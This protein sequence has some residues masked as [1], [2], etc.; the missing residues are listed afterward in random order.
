MAKKINRVLLDCSE[1]YI[2]NLNTGIQRVVKNIVKRSEKMS[3]KYGVT[4][5]PIVLDSKNGYVDLRFFMS[6]KDGGNYNNK[7]NNKLSAGEVRE[8]IKRLLKEN[9]KSKETD[10]VFKF[11]KF[12]WRLM[13]RLKYRLI[14]MR[15]SC[16]ALSSRLSA[17]LSPPPLS[18]Q[19]N[20]LLSSPPSAKTVL[21]QKG[22]LLILLDG[23]WGY[24]YNN[25]FASFCR[26]VKKK[27]G[28]IIAV[29]YDII[30]LTNPEFFEKETVMRFKNKFN[31]LKNS[32]DIIMTISKNEA[33]NIK[34]YLK[35]NLKIE[36]KKIS[37][38]DLGCD[39]ADKNGDGVRKGLK[40]LTEIIKTSLYL[41]VGTVEPRKGY[42]YIIDA[43]EELWD[44]GFDGFLVI[45][46]KIGW[47]VED[48]LKKI[49]NSAYSGKKLFV[50]NDLNDGELE[51]L[52]NNADAAICASKREGFSLP[53]VEA[54]FYGVEA[55]ASDIPVF[56]EIGEKYPVF[57]YFKPDKDGLLSAVKKFENKAAESAGAVNGLSDKAAPEN[58]NACANGGFVTW[59]QSVDAF[60]S[61]IFAMYNNITLTHR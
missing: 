61:K 32:I 15:Q 44:G 27:G 43:F 9:F 42:D 57:S 12:L 55:L 45:V 19:P 22:D 20:P 11:S 40:D 14:G 18:S 21:P 39:F 17:P 24:R 7:L 38:F 53:L 1:T 16:R 51:F 49:E 5:M 52:Y 13:K 37:Y 41:T 48:V 3:E 58:A 59:E 60:Y 47:D 36:N 2:E 26:G 8:F 56:R 4:I 34:K 31:A 33:E 25:Y 50:F 10:A 46:G 29:I 35:D 6:R 28:I 23:F 30:P 54:A